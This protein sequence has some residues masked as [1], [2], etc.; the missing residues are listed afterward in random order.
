MMSIPATSCLIPARLRTCAGVVASSKTRSHVVDL[1]DFVRRGVGYRDVAAGRE[2]SQQLDAGLTD[3]VAD[4]PAKEG[5]V[6]LHRPPDVRQLRDHRRADRAVDRVVVLAAE[7][8]VIDPRDARDV[9]PERS[10][11]SP[12]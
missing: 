8:I 2:R 4:H 7:Q 9:R 11:Q 5:P 10:R 3:Q 1:G 12:S 6:P